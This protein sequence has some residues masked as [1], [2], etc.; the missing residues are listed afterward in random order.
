MTNQMKGPAM[1]GSCRKCG[2][3]MIVERVLDYY[4]PLTPLKCVNCGCRWD[5]LAALQGSRGVQVNRSYEGE[6]R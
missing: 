6:T 3:F 5:P 1:K 4:G 2:G